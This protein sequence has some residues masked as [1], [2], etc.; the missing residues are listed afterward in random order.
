[1]SI[2]SLLRGLTITLLFGSSTALNA[3]SLDGYLFDTRP[4]ILFTSSPSNPKFVQQLSAFAQYEC[5]F[6]KRDLEVLTVVSNGTSVIDGS[7]LSNEDVSFL[8]DELEVG[9]YTEL[10]VLVGKD[11]RVKLRAHMPLSARDLI[12]LVDAMPMRR[13]EV[14]TR[15]T[16]GCSAA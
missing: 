13:I 9:P 2:R 6:F 3:G 1:M 10:L 15:P 5:E 4:V 14:A 8:K 11:G 16:V 12:R 7:I